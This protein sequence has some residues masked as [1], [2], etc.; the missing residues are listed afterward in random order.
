M[1]KTHKI[2]LADRISFCTL[3]KII[4]DFYGLARVR[5]K[6]RTPLQKVQ[7]WTEHL[8]RIQIVLRL[9]LGD[10]SHAHFRY[11]LIEKKFQSG[12][13]NELLSDEI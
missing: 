8:N 6:I 2:P 3:K 9:T 10:K 13:S 7:D 11:N 4:K 1:P 5:P 12:F